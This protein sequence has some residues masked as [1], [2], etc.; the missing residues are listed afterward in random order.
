MFMARCISKNWLFA[1]LVGCGCFASSALAQ[2]KA[3]EPKKPEVK[4]KAPAIIDVDLFQR[5]MPQGLPKEQ[6]ELLLKQIEQ[7]EA[8]LQR[9]L[10]QLNR[11]PGIGAN[12]GLNPFLPMI[13][14]QRLPANFPQIPNQLFPNP[15]LMRNVGEGKG[16]LGIRVKSPDDD[17]IA[18]FGLEEGKGL[19]VET[20]YEGSVA[21][22]A[23]LKEKDI[24]LEFNG[25]EVSS[26]GPA[27]TN[28]VNAVQPGKTVDL[29]VLRDGMKE[30]IKGIALP[31]LP[32]NPLF[33]NGA[34]RIQRGFQVPFPQND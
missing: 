12:G 6:L 19:F 34:L 10:D 7:L 27:F 15:R 11:M 1:A 26:D 24:L 21:A 2:P 5:A 4:R 22:K 3:D 29:V 33:R 25:K 16:R 23:G 28:I 14:N 8:Q 9:D 30:T 31:E 20:V 17:T 18:T 13:P 32:Q